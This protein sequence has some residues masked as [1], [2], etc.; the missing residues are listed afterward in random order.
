MT[1]F[2]RTLAAIVLLAA[3]GPA[4]AGPVDYLRDVRP[5]PV[6]R[7]LQ[8][9]RPRHGQKAGC[10]STSATSATKKGAVVPGKPAESVA[11][12][13]HR[14]GDEDRMP[15]ADAGER[16]TAGQIETLTKRGSRRG[17]STPRTGRS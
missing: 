2:A 15:P 5:D 11:L 10:G 3:A 13:P 4:A 6:E 9:P 14:L 8:V 17:P 12:D 7:L 16:L 1:P